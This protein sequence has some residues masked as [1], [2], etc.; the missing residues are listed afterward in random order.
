M[1]DE[2]QRQLRE[3]RELAANWGLWC[4]TFG[5][6]GSSLG[7]SPRLK[8]G[9]IERQYRAPPQWHPPQPRGP[10]PHDPSG[11]EFQL[12]FYKLP[13]VY[14]RVL[15][16]EFCRR[17]KLLG[18]HNWEATNVTCAVLAR[19]SPRLYPIIVDRALFAIRNLLQKKSQKGY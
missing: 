3:I 7:L 9:G 4:I 16:V 5:E 6:M 12:V 11:L 10:E 1:D 8:H 13:E 19:I 18:Q 17:P 2:R 14:R 15:R